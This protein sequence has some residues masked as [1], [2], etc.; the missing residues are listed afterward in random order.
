[1]NQSH[2]LYQ[3]RD[4]KGV[5]EC[6]LTAIVPSQ[7]HPQSDTILM[8]W[9]R[10]GRVGGDRLPIGRNSNQSRDRKGVGECGLTA[11]VPSQF[12]PQSDTIL[13]FWN[14]FGRVG[15]D[16]LPYGRGSEA[17]GFFNRTL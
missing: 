7:F 4:R 5:G 10:F 16:R 13:M 12:H 11:I 1:M 9:K 14:R 2:D 3:S 6:R 15:G 8:F 17:C